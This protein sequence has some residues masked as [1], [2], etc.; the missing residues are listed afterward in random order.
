MKSK[1]YKIKEENENKKS[2][3]IENENENKE[4]LKIENENENKEN[5]KIEEKNETI[6]F[7]SQGVIGKYLSKFA[8]EVAK[9][10]E[11]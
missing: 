10:I 1:E 4:N 3:K 6:I 7:I 8:Y 5:L 2:L 11:R 9:R